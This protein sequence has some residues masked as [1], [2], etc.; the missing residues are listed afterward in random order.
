MIRI[1]LRRATTLMACVLLLSACQP[2]VYLMPTPVAISEGDADPF[3]QNPDLEK[4]N[5][6][7][8]AYATN[9]LPFGTENSR[10]YM[11]LFDKGLR[12]GAAEITIGNEEKSWDQLRKASTTEQRDAKIPLNL[13]NAVEM[14]TIDTT[15]N[16][17][18]LDA[19]ARNFF[20]ELNHALDKS[21]D[22]DL[23]LYVHGANS[24]FYRANAQ[25]AQFR[26]FTG[27]NSVVMTY[28][29]PSAES[30]LRYAVDVHNAKKTVPT[31]ARLLQLLARHSNARHID[32]I[33][34]SA[35]PQVV[36]PALALLAEQYG[37]GNLERARKELRIGELYFAAPDLD[38]RQLLI[39]LET[40]AQIARHVTVAINPNDFVLSLSASH[41]GTSR[42]GAPDPN[43]LTEEETRSV[44]E[45]SKTLPVDFIWISSDHIPGLSRGS[46]GFWYEHPWV[47][48]DVLVQ[49]LLDARPDQRGLESHVSEVDSKVWYFP[50]DYPERIDRILS[51]YRSRQK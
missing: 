43:E 39:D 21:L 50:A 3:A 38:F 30:L 31:F 36:S 15:G 45:A 48:T 22:K 40:H 51:D 14:A 42:A 19:D 7:T 6:V 9:R 16:L 10:V 25:A 1:A 34:Y 29:W 13:R 32:I 18:K 33:A 24:N 37:G 2:T 8:V 11:T 28:S 35:G 20:D 17:E 23:V 12:L 47:S 26:H 44:I 49:L 4:S 27:R 46:H 41:H 5:R